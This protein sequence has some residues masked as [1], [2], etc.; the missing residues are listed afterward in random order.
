[1]TADDLNQL[2]QARLKYLD[3]CARVGGVLSGLVDDGPAYML[4]AAASVATCGIRQ[5]ESWRERWE[6]H[7]AIGLEGKPVCD[8]C[9][10]TGTWDPWPCVEA[11]SVCRE[12]GVKP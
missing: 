9:A 4:A 6:R 12:I 8:I 1:M 2:V 3:T 5:V 7:R 10:I 11:L